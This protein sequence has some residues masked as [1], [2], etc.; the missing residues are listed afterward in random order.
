MFME[1]MNFFYLFF[2]LLFMLS[3]LCFVFFLYFL[4]L[5]KSI[6]FEWEILSV[7]S[8]YME[9]VMFFDWM[10]L[11][12]LSVVFF[13]SSFV[14]LYSME[15]MS[16]K[17]NQFILLIFLFV[18]SMMLFIISPNIISIL[19]G[20]DG[21]G[22]VSFILII[23]FQSNKSKNSGM[24]TIMLNRM[25]DIMIIFAS[26]FYYMIGGMNFLYF[27]D[28][29]MK[30]GMIMIIFASMTKSAQ[31]PFSSWLPAAMAA[32][33]PV[34]S[35]VHSSTLVTAGIYLMMRFNNYIMKCEMMMKF[36]FIIGTITMFMAGVGANFENDLKKI[37]ALSTL[38]Q[39]GL[40]MLTLSFGLMS[41]SFFHL[42]THALFKA[43]LFLCAGVMI[44]NYKD[45][46]DIRILSY[47]V[48]Y[49]PITT[50]CFN[51]ANLSLCGFPF[52]S[53]FYSKDLI[54]EMFIISEK[55]IIFFFLC[56][57]S[58]SLTVS[59]TF[60]LLYYLSFSKKM[61]FC[62]MNKSESKIFN[63]VLIS[64]TFFSIISGVILNFLLNSFF[65]EIFLSF[66]NK[67][68]IP[69]ILIM[70]LLLSF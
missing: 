28:F 13:I 34:S 54:I 1:Y 45:I 11:L 40:M 5:N 9:M 39:L 69:M 15:Y 7:N 38:S 31:M 61:Y 59:Y 36:L 42:T 37:I 12:F 49:L 65:E 22:L 52:L 14:S 3:I 43:L 16:K 35:L 60:R 64:L 70:G 48:Y 4:K 41:F 10:G 44:H 33:T 26:W 32:P 6:F 47:M 51:M 67:M 18:M 23:F 8:N 19:I 55:N 17:K 29:P 21:L 57:L 27:Y 25:G 56:L 20:W 46:Q 68:I 30:L 63:F 24:Q 2:I 66:Y 53:G 62:M 50:M 58:T